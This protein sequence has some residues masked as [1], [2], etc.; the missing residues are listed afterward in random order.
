VKSAASAPID[1]G[2]LEHTLAPFGASKTLP[3]DAYTSDELLQWERRHFFARAWTAVG[4]A[5]D[6]HPGDVKAV[7][8]GSE[9]VLLTRDGSGQ[10]H[11]FYNVCRHR[12]HEIVAPGPSRSERVLKCP[13]HSWV[14][15]LGGEL[16]GAP[17]F[18]GLEGFDK[19]DYPLT[20]MRFVDWHGWIFVNPSSDAPEFHDYIG[21]LEHHV[22]AHAPERLITA[23]RHDYEAA[24]NWKL[25]VENYHECYHCPTIHPELCRVSPP[26]SGSNYEPDGAWVGGSMELSEGAATMSI[27][28]ASPVPALPGLDERRRRDVYYFGLFPN[29]LI[30]LHP[31]YVMTHRIEP[32]S[33]NRT[34]IECEWLFDP[35]AVAPDDF[36]PRY[37]TE[38]WDI[39][40][41]QDWEA[42]EGVQR[43]VSSYGYRQGPLSPREDAVYQFLAMTAR[44]YIDG[45]ISAPPPMSEEKRALGLAARGSSPRPR[46]KT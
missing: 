16:K 5:S 34:R 41:R 1:R 32:L 33:V 17:H 2:A 31:D 42:C 43:G 21:S 36:D 15:S 18:G 38:F 45:A 24:A 8:A 37:A 46:A 23:A 35:S 39:T 29:L 13:Y 27:D 6:L 7:N 22:A 3:A 28:G 11:V 30:S 19:S 20:R 10:L 40:N 25:L 26:D 9:S 44:G 4:R 12:G 14:Y